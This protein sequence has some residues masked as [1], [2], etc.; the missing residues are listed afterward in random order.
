MQLH[1]ASHQSLRRVFQTN[2]SAHDITESLLTCDREAPADEV[3]RI[4]EERRLQ[5]IGVREMGQV[6]GYVDREQIKPGMSELPVSSFD[7]D[8]V[9]FDTEPLDRVVLGLQN[10]PRLFVSV[11]GRV[12]G[13]VTRTDLQKPAA[14]MWLFGMVTLMEM[15]ITQLIAEEAGDR[16][17]NS[18]SDARVQKA[19]DLRVERQ[20][21][22][23]DVTLIDCLQFGDKVQIVARD[24]GLRATTRFT[25]RRR[26]EEAGKR[27]GAASQQ[28]GSRTR[29]CDGRLGCARRT[30]QQL[31]ISRLRT[32]LGRRHKYQR[33]ANG[34]CR[35]APWDLA[36]MLH[37]RRCGINGGQR[38]GSLST[39]VRS[40]LRVL[41]NRGRQ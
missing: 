12:G 6:I 2:F 8:S 41:F 7:T 16:W 20:R 3:G 34:T 1:P 10:H 28:S 14:R 18:L 5:V 4:M 32:C 31:R 27:L 17:Q 29:Y 23:Q 26:V 22:G 38:F 21:R 9:I 33:I 36:A 19:R 30:F 39:I 35:F 24:E 13:I 25:S 37:Q 11:F 15:R 40:T